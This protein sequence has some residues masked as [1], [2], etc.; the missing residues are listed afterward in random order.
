MD[1][2]RVVITGMGAVS[3]F[4]QG[5]DV[6]NESLVQGKS[7]IVKFTELEAMEGIGSHVAGVAGNIDPMMIPRKYRRSMSTMSIFSVLASQEALET[8]KLSTDCCGQRK[9]GDCPG[10]HDRQH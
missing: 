4:G 2:K 5:T 10:F 1:M 9:H 7:G 6:L 3:P 8:G